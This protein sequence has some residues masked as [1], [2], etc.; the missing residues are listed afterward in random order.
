MRQSG[1]EDEEQQQQVASFVYDYAGMHL[2]LPL[3]V[4]VG[5][6]AALSG[7]RS[8]TVKSAN[9]I[10]TNTCDMHFKHTCHAFTY[11]GALC[12]CCCICCCQHDQLLANF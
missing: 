12:Y 6:T 3:F 2:H 11:Q 9:H 8:L 4:Q 1:T 5:E 10:A 7:V